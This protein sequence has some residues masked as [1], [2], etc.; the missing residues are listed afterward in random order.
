MCRLDVEETEGDADFRGRCSSTL[1]GVN[2]LQSEGPGTLPWHLKV[3]TRRYAQR[4]SCSMTLTVASLRG[5]GDMIDM[6][7]FSGIQPICGFC[8][9]APN[10]G[11]LMAWSAPD[12]TA[13]AGLW[14]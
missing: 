3:L 4:R 6:E 10:Q 9:S 5:L 2:L 1:Q 14:N 11:S 8:P 13:R 12:P 7:S